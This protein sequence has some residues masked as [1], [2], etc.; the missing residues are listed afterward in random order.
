VRAV[1]FSILLAALGWGTSS[2]ATRGALEQG[3]GPYAI[4]TYRSL[5]GAVAVVVFLVVMRRGLP[6]G[7]A[8]WKTGLVQGITNLAVPYILLNIALQHASA[9][10]VGL[11]V[12]LVPMLTAV[13]AH[14]ML[15][16]ERLGV[17]KVLG[18]A[19]AAGGV[20][21]LLLAGDSGLVDGGRPDLAL[22]LGFLGAASIAFGGTY[23]KIHAGAYTPLQVT[24]IHFVSGAA[25]IAVVALSV[26]GPSAPQNME[27]WALMTYLGLFGQFMPF[28]LFYR[29][30]QRVSATYASMVGY[31]VPLI[32][33]T[34]GVILLDE[35]LQAGIV[36]G[37]LLILVGVLITDRS[38]RIAVIAAE[39]APEELIASAE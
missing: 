4:A 35:R 9:G 18:L 20:G 25:V 31:V 36:L 27:T 7:S 23:A 32:A 33:V 14:F 17:V 8:T 19:V 11:L 38:E 21:V 34:A 10:F 6:R 24:G 5:I 3:M 39:G 13:L 37:G 1:W 30:L 12:A 16:A 28:V 29:L 22:L 26:E 2:V 15:P